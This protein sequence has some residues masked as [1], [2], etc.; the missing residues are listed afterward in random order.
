[1]CVRLII[2]RSLSPC[3]QFKLQVNSLAQILPYKSNR[4]VLLFINH[5]QRV[6]IFTLNV[7][8]QLLNDPDGRIDPEFK[9]SNVKKFSRSVDCKFWQDEGVDVFEIGVKIVAECPCFSFDKLRDWL[10]D[11][12]LLSLWINDVN[13]VDISLN[14]PSVG[15]SQ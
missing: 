14:W 6:F 8:W 7:N 3:Q 11:S 4:N 1:M 5:C 2:F 12:G 13:A 15:R 10:R 9:P